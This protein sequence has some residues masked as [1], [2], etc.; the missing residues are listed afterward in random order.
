MRIRSI[1]RITAL[2]VLALASVLVGACGSGPVRAGPEAPAPPSVTAPVTTSPSAPNATPATESG[3]TCL[4]A[5]IHTVDAAAGGRPWR[6]LCIAVGGLVRLENLGPESLRARSWDNVDCDYEAAVHECRLIHLGTVNFTITNTHG[7]RALT[8]VVGKASSPPKPSP[9]CTSTVPYNLDALNGGPPWRA[10]CVKVGA[11]LRVENLGP[12][13]LS[14]DPRAIVSCWY[15]AAVRECTFVRPGTV[16]L[17]T[18]RSAEIEPRTV[19]VVV[20][21]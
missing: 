16:R 15:E 19:T 11:V 14:V 8:V 6:S 5:V 3:P 4:G 18:T 21:R 17:T 12:E 2:G 20:V 7:V 13:G 10:F 9:A 1:R